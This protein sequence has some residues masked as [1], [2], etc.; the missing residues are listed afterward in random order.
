MSDQT[1]VYLKCHRCPNM[2]SRPAA[3]WIGGEPFCLTCA[4]RVYALKL[5]GWRKGLPLSG[6][7]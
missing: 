3:I 1:P 6:P 5:N 2:I 7:E 4:N